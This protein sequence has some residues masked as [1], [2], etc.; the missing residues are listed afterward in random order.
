MS[1]QGREQAVERMRS[2]GVSRP[3]IDT[4]V[5]HY[6]KLA[7]GATGLIAEA[8]VE[9]ALPAVL[10][11][12]LPRDEAA[13][14][15]AL[16]RTVVITL[17]GGLGTSMGLAGPKSLLPV[18]DGL[19]FLDI[20]VRQ[21]LALR[22]RY[23]VRLPLLLMDSFSTQD[24]TLEV[25][26]GYPDLPVG[27]LPLDFLQSQEP[28]LRADDL[29]PVDWPADPR[30][31]W[32][33]PGHGDL[34]PSLLASG[35]LDRLLADGY[36]YAFVSNVDNLGAVPDPALAAWFAG[37]GAGYAAE[38]CR[39]TEMDKKG[40]HLVRRRADGRLVLRDTAQTAPEELVH[41]MDGEKHP[42]VNTNNLWFD[43]ERLRA[44]LEERGGVMDL[45]LIRNAKTVD[46]TDK[47]STPVI[48]IE[49]AM[50]GAVELFED[51][52]SVGVSR[53]RFAPVK[54]TNEL[55]LLR[56]DA[57]RLDP[58]TY[59]LTRTVEPSPVVDLVKDH[60]AMISDFDARFPAG[61]PSLVDATRL[62]VEG[63]WTFGADVRVRGEAVLDEQGGQVPDGAT[64]P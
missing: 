48:Q 61:A 9:P 54:T 25:L 49:S 30:L 63:D 52:V 60:Y 41:F 56:S 62:Q 1:T 22:A 27:D 16:D 34:Y 24:A 19:T 13:A 37:S 20:T 10:Q 11:E 53:E 31:E 36:R 43:L 38:V 23:G 2:A 58:Q 14:R 39:R 51:A 47:A 46:P 18:H 44:M 42:Y 40:G 50:G 57:Y 45:P 59:R 26:A 29:T 21:V 8:D 6:D 3:A 15:E 64:L 33:P 28:K 35:L 7:E 32:C 12:D 55:L 4:F 5:T 17:N